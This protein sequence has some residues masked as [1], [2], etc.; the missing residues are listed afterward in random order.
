MIT[1]PVVLKLLEANMQLKDIIVF[2]HKLSKWQEHR[3]QLSK[4]IASSDSPAPSPVISSSK[5]L[6]QSKLENCPTLNSILKRS[7]ESARLINSY[8][9]S[10]RDRN[11]LIDRV[12]KYFYFKRCPFTQQLRDNIANQIKEQFMDENKVK[13]DLDSN[14]NYF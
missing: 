12:V 10:V 11:I 6:E 13:T 7:T 5:Q 3:I 9:L 2:Q 4:P 14:L 8:Q 1:P